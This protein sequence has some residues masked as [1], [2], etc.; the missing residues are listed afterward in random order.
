[1]NAT[2]QIQASLPTIGI[3]VGIMAILA[4]VE[5][6]VPLQSRGRWRRTRLG[7]NLALTAI[8]ILINLPLTVA[9][10]LALIWLDSIGFGL[11]HWLRIGPIGGIALAVLALDFAFY[12]A[13]VAMHKIGLL[14]RFHR[15]HHTDPFVDVTTTI[16]QHPGE[17][18]I[19]YAF[20][21]STAIFTG[22]RGHIQRGGRARPG[23]SSLGWR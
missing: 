1:M 2:T 14:W 11:R 5:V 8:T 9:L 7:P 13:H 21:A 15:V 3:I 17:A 22:D 19:R 6:V 10:T 20:L 18:L 16:R 23:Y 12:V 4:V